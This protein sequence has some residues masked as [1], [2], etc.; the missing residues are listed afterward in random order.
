MSKRWEPVNEFESVACASGAKCSIMV[1]RDEDRLTVYSDYTPPVSVELPDDLRLCRQVHYGLC[2][3]VKSEHPLII[4]FFCVSVVRK[5]LKT[6][7][8]RYVYFFGPHRHI[9]INGRAIVFDV[10]DI[11]IV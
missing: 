1:E 3:C 8:K 5:S 6:I 7:K 10:V 9:P 11:I 2:Q 4:Y